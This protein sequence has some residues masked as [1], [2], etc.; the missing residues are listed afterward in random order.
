MPAASS[1]LS[2]RWVL[3]GML[4]AVIMEVPGHLPAKVVAAWNWGTSPSPAPAVCN[5]WSSWSDCSVT[6][7]QGSQSRTRT[8][9][10]S[11]YD[12]TDVCF[13]ED[14]PPPCQDWESWGS[15]SQTC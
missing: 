8:G 2:C 7:G 3:A 5:V 13:M 4:G 1:M 9:S 15:C 14:C 11:F 12:E 6:C 10:C